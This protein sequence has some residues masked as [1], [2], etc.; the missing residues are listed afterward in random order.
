M[1]LCLPGTPA[2]TSEDG[3]STAALDLSKIL[4]RLYIVTASMK[5]LDIVDGLPKLVF[6]ED[7]TVKSVS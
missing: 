5:T 7:G 6:N 2:R 1:K 4:V 3:R